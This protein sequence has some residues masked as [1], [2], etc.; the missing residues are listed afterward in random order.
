MVA[1]MPKSLLERKEAWAAKMREKLAGQAKLRERSSDRLPPGQHRTEGFPVLDLGIHPKVAEDEWSLEVSGDVELPTTF[2]L[3]SFAALPRVES[4]SDFHCVTTWSKFDVAWGGVR[5]A[6]VIDRVLPKPGAEFVFFTGYDGYTTNLPLA[7]LVGD[8]VLLADTLDGQ[9]LPLRHGGPV[10][11]VVPHLY[12]W[13]ATKFIRK[14]E[15]RSED[16]PGYWEKRGYSN[17]ADPWT[18]D[19]FA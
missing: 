16:E 4:V 11:V 9:P 5:F 8:D 18:D 19:R 6:E 10:R 2:D 17:S 14:M 1:A 13:K 3:R 7:D 12:A 15:F